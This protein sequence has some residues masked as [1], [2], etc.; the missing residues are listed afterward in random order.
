MK[1]HSDICFE[2]AKVGASEIGTFAVKSAEK[3]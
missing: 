3:H 1:H 2:N